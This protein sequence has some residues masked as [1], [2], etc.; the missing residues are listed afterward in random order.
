MFLY[1]ILDKL[2]KSD[3]YSVEFEVSDFVH[4]VLKPYSS[5]LL[6]V[7]ANEAIMKSLVED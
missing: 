3:N 4:D 1:G 5:F 7:D 2:V 6:S